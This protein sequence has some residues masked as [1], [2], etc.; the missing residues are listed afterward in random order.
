MS[1]SALLEMAAH[2]RYYAA[3]KL[4]PQNLTRFSMGQAIEARDSA[5]KP[6]MQPR[7]QPP[8]IRCPLRAKHSQQ[9]PPNHAPAH[10]AMR[11]ARD[12]V[13]LKWIPLR[14]RT[15][16]KIKELEH[17]SFEKAGQFFRDMRERAP[18]HPSFFRS[19]LARKLHRGKTLLADT[20][21]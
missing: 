20:W 1:I 11:R 14:D 8:P 10:A 6:R 9:P 19:S 16:I 5:P 17:V 7:N 2:P 4:A 15:Q 18:F 21:S 12:R 3:K 13:P